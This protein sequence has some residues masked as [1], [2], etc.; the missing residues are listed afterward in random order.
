[1][2]NVIYRVKDGDVKLEKYVLKK[3]IVIMQIKKLFFKLLI[4]KY[5]RLLTSFII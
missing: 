3:I 5:I 2:E 1:M 4:Y